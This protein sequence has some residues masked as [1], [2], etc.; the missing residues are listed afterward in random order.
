[1]RAHVCEWK[2]VASSEE[3]LTLKKQ[4][5]NNGFAAAD[6][7]IHAETGHSSVRTF[8]ETNRTFVSRWATVSRHAPQR[9]RTDVDCLPN[10]M[11][12]RL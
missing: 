4:K 5:K 6:A 3:E 12:E 10:D 11:E 2:R 9:C 7:K 8:S 1:M